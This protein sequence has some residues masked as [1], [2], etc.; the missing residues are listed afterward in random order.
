MDCEV[1]LAKSSQSIKH[2][3]IELSE[4]IKQQDLILESI[5]SETDK[6][7]KALLLNMGKFERVV[8]I[9]N[10]DPRN[11]II[12]CLLFTAL[13]LLYFLFH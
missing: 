6:N 2:A 9:L 10:N 8:H 13:G 5:D 7:S 11:K 4:K 1:K 3:V 12:A